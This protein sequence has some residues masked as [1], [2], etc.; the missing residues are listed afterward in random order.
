MQRALGGITVQSPGLDISWTTSGWA[1]GEGRLSLGENST[2]VVL[3]VAA[4]SSIS[5]IT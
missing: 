3:K 1:T 4:K 5:S 2:A